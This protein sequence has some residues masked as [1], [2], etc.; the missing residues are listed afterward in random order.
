MQKPMDTDCQPYGEVRGHDVC[1]MSP[2]QVQ[3]KILCIYRE[4]DKTNVVKCSQMVNLGKQYVGALSTS[5]T[6]LM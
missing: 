2:K 4:D 3:K 6:T 5:L 1:M